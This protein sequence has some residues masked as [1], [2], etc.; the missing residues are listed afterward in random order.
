MSALSKS[1]QNVIRLIYKNY[2][3]ITKKKTTNFVKFSNIKY[4]S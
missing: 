3:F 2:V 1:L 4:Y